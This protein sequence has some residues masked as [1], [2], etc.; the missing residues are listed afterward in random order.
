MAN[1]ASSTSPLYA[2]LTLACI[3]YSSFFVSSILFIIHL[4]VFKFHFCQNNRLTWLIFPKCA[5]RRVKSVRRKAVF[6]FKFFFAH[7]LHPARPYTLILY[8][9]QFFH[10][11][12]LVVGYYNSAFGYPLPKLPSQLV[13]KRHKQIFRSLSRFIH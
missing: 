6:F 12:R 9:A 4:F 3:L 7:Q 10:P 8:F 13:L 11:C 5:K 2:S 1:F